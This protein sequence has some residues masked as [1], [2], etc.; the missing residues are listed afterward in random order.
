[1][2]VDDTLLDRVHTRAREFIGTTRRVPLGRLHER[3]LQRFA[4]V[5]GH[6]DQRLRDGEVAAPLF[7]SAVLGWQAGPEEAA[8]TSDGNAPQSVGDVPLDGLRL[9]GG[10]QDLTFHEPVVA[11]TDVVMEVTV[12]DVVRK[13]GRSGPLLVLEVHRRYL[14]E[15]GTLLVECRESFLAR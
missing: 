9:M 12:H 13:D 1:V 14:D 3:D 6:T 4:L 11:G 8:L 2:S 7:L 5:V 15:R 10:G